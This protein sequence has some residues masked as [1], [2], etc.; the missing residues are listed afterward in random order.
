MAEKYPLTERAKEAIR[1][2]LILL[3]IFFSLFPLAILVLDAFRPYRE[4]VSLPPTILPKNVTLY[5]FAEIG[6]KIDLPRMTWNTF[7]VAGLITLSTLFLGTLAGYAFAKLNFKGKEKVFVLLISKL[8]IPSIVLVIPWSFMIVRMGLMD[9]LFAIILPNLTGAW[10]IFFMRQYIS[11]LPEDY[12]D[13]ARIDG[14]GEL[15]TFFR[16]VLPLIKPALATA[17]IINF[18]WG[19]NEF[20]WP[21]LVLTSKENFLLS[22]GVAIVKYSGGTLTEGTVNFAMLAA[23]S[24]IYALP[25]LLVY[26]ILAKQFVQSIVLSG[27]KR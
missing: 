25:I 2:I 6:A 4:I 16:I 12:F 15:Y 17:A 11:Q 7:V 19:W 21:L 10:T 13:S 9:T 14:A 20:L 1:N 3:V 18:L 5:N 22:I 27:L 23:L 24:L 26:M 8:M